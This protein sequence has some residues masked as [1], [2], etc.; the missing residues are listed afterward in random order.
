MQIQ[1]RQLKDTRDKKKLVC[2]FLLF[3]FFLG[4][5]VGGCRAGDE[6]VYRKRSARL[7]HTPPIAQKIVQLATIDFEIT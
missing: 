6:V 7:N 3:F 2:V 5:G 4:G 1:I